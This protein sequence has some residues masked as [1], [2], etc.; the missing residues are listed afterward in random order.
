MRWTRGRPHANTKRYHNKI[1]LKPCNEKNLLKRARS[2][3][4]V[5]CDVLKTRNSLEH[6]IQS[7]SPSVRSSPCF[8]LILN[9]GIFIHTWEQYSHTLEFL[10]HLRKSVL[11]RCQHVVFKW[12]SPLLFFCKPLIMWLFFKMLMHLNRIT[13]E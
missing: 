9:S 6:I 10:Y 4:F 13:N 12:E 1:I 7:D 8:I 2:C 5:S 11:S 3:G